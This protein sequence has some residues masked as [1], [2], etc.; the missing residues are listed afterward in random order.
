MFGR[1]Y[2]FEEE[3][4]PQRAAAEEPPPADVVCSQDIAT[5][6]IGARG[7]EN[8]KQPKSYSVGLLA[9]GDELAVAAVLPGAG[10]DEPLVEAIDVPE[11]E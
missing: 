4:I 11:L 2:N 6:G 7:V 3:T 9:G 1:C 10:S 8:A 5:L